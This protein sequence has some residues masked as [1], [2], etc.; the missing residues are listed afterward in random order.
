LI[1]SEDFITLLE[2]VLDTATN[3]GLFEGVPKLIPV[4]FILAAG[5]PESHTDPV[6]LVYRALN[7]TATYFSTGAPVLSKIVPKT[8]SFRELFKE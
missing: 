8:T 4:Q 7:P 6:S 2:P 5:V 1:V 3:S